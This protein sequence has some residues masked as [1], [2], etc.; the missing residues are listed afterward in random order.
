MFCF[1]VQFHLFGLKSYNIGYSY[2][3]WYLI[4]NKQ[5]QNVLERANSKGN[6]T[7]WRSNNTSTCSICST[8]TG[9]SFVNEARVKILPLRRNLFVSGNIKSPKVSMRN[10]CS[11]IKSWKNERTWKDVEITWNNCRNKRLTAVFHI[12]RLRLKEV[13]SESSLSL[14]STF[15][16]RLK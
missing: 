15:R 2:I 12:S 6:L 10:Y 14:F 4:M 13:E 9:M 16:V 7:P 1:I 3:Q 5:V 8:E 11:P